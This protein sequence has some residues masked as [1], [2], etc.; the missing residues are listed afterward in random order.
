MSMAK[1]KIHLGGCICGRIRFE[2]DAPAAK[3][4]TCSC[5]MC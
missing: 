2:A 3:P 4:H 1:A 5:R